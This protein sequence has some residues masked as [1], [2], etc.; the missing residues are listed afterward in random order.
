MESPSKAL[1]PPHEAPTIDQEDTFSDVIEGIGW[2]NLNSSP[3]QSIE[4]HGPYQKGPPKWLTNM[5]ECVHPDEVG[6][7]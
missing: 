4:Q 5:L 1:S 2:I 3:S 6:K 7:T